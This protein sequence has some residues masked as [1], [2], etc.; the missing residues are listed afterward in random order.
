VKHI[1]LHISGS[2]PIRVR[3]VHSWAAGS[4]IFFYCVSPKGLRRCRTTRTG[5]SGDDGF[6][7]K[8]A[9]SHRCVC[10]QKIEESSWSHKPKFGHTVRKSEVEQNNQSLF[11]RIGRPVSLPFVF[12]TMSQSLMVALSSYAF[13]ALDD[14]NPLLIVLLFHVF[15]SDILWF[16]P[17]GK[18]PKCMHRTFQSCSGTGQGLWWSTGGMDW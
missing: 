16:H 2:W 3:L 15:C 5:H 7:H 11:Q 1:L 8:F 9:C 4:T 18:W 10:D 17:R 13:F 6:R 12:R 14:T